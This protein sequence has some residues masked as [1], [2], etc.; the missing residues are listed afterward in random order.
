[1]TRQIVYS[2]VSE[3]ALIDNIAALFVSDFKWFLDTLYPNDDL[4]DFVERTL[5]QVLGINAPF[6]ALAPVRNASVESEDGHYLREALRVD[7]LIG[8]IDDAPDTV[9]RRIERYMRA[10]EALLRAA[11]KDEMFGIT[12]RDNTWGFAL[13]VEHVYRQD[14]RTNQVQFF[15]DATLQ[16]TV[17]IYER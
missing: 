7:L 2:A 9:T 12:N 5:G 6:M 1:M 16:I 8:V 17:N 3:E 13:D 14:I 4:Q 15:R 10:A 11:N